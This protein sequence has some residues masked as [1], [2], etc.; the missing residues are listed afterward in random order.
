MPKCKIYTKKYRGKYVLGKV[1]I[2]ILNV[3][4]NDFQKTEIR[5]SCIPN[6]MFIFYLD[7]KWRTYI[8]N[9][10]SKLKTLNIYYLKALG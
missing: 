10:S 1:F 5:F 9:L 2:K 8:S 7:L 3:P 4:W 6:H